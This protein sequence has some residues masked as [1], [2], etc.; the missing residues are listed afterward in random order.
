M[1][2][3][4]V[5]GLLGNSRFQSITMSETI[6]TRNAVLYDSDCPF[7]VFQGKMMTWLDWFGALRLL[8]IKDPEAME[9]A[10]D[11]RREDLQEAMHVVTREGKIFRGARAIRFISFRLPAAVPLGLVLWFPGVIFIAEKV[12]AVVSR[13]RL[14]LSKLFGC[15]GACV[16]MPTRTAGREDKIPDQP[17]TPSSE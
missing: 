12:Y 7:C 13:N 14:H 15:R 8:P 4:Q 17:G 5:D 6:R 1:A 10:P 9:L 16:I 11:V 3:E 2:W